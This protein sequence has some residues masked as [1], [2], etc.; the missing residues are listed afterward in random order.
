MQNQ[1]GSW[2]L[3]RQDPFF[4]LAVL[5]PHSQRIMDIQEG[6]ERVVTCAGPASRYTDTIYIYL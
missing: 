3:S 6:R 4:M 5:L 2:W 1:A